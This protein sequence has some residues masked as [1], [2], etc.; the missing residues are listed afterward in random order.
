MYFKRM[1]AGAVLAAATASSAHA[2][3]VDLK[4]EDKAGAG[5][6]FQI[7]GP[8]V[9]LDD[10]IALR[11]AADDNDY[12]FHFTYDTANLSANHGLTLVSGRIGAITDF[13]GYAASMQFSPSNSMMISLNKVATAGSSTYSSGIYLVLQDNNGDIPATLPTSVNF[14]ALNQANFSVETRRNGGVG[15]GYYNVYYSQI[16]GSIA[17][18]PTGNGNPPGGGTNPGGGEPNPGTGN[19]GAPVPEPG[20]WALMILGLG[21]A[22]AMLRR[23]QTAAA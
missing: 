15:L 2:V 6:G 5:A 23:R 8:N 12:A 11:N 16:Q 10:Q 13:S 9:Y 21:S 3:V 18:V 20:T 4:F 22:G 1:L 17:E 14:A 7:S 19:P